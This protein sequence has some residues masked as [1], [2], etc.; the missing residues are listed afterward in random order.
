MELLKFEPIYQERVWGGRGL[1]S[2][3]GRKLPSDSRIGESWEIVDRPEAQSIIANGSFK[4]KT[5][6]EVIEAEAE[7]LMGPTYDRARPFPILVKWL[8]CQE[9][10]SL[11]VHP[12]AS[13][14]DSLGGE[15]KTENWYIAEAEH[16]AALLVGLKPGVTREQFEAAIKDNTLEDLVGRI[17]VRSGDSMFVYSGRIH[18]IDAGNLILEIQQNSD[19][20]YRVYDWGR[21]GLDG[22]PRQLHVEESLKSIDFNDSGAEVIHPEQGVQQLVSSDIFTLRKIPVGFKDHLVIKGGEQPRIL[23]VVEGA[24]REK[25]SNVEIRRSENVLLPYSGSFE[26]EPLDNQAVVLLTEDFV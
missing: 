19:T 11:Q 13:I 23:S 26:F 22:K 14:A 25:G 15:P 20:T 7:F 3:L 18:A 9:R 12:P 5:L 17:K 1:E 24:I 2:R 10:L 8:D 6:R 16:D 21:T 4:G